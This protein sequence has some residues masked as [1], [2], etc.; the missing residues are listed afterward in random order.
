MQKKRMQPIMKWA[1]MSKIEIITTIIT[2]RALNMSTI[3]ATNPNINTNTVVVDDDDGP[4]TFVDKR[5][6]KTS[7]PEIKQEPYTRGY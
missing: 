4:N 2:A 3:T 7:D 1:L 5:Q 6:I